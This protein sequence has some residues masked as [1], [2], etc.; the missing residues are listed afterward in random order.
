MGGAWQVAPKSR[1]R[2]VLVEGLA[3]HDSRLPDFV[4]LDALAD[5]GPLAQHALAD[6][7]DIS[8]SGL[9]GFPND[10]ERRGCAG[11]NDQ[12]GQARRVRSTGAGLRHGPAPVLVTRAGSG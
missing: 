5:F 8:R 3:G 6:R 1:E 7:L 4:V 12:R 10:I 9:V 2:S 11:A